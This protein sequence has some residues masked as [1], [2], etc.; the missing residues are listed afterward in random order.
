MAGETYYL[1]Q[2]GDK[3]KLSL[4]ISVLIIPLAIMVDTMV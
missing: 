1:V 3:G 4:E 2:G